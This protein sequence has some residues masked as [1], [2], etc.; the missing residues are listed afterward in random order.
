M[1]RAVA[2]AILVA[3]LGCA[4]PGSP[5]GGEIDRSPPRVIETVPAA[6]DTLTDLGE[7]AIIRFDER[8]SERLQG[9]AEL[10]EAVLVSPAGREIRVDRHSRSFEIIP[11]GGW[12]PDRVY[13]IQV[14][15]VFQD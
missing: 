2:G 9:V 1:S 5:P 14:L 13:R 7:P 3:A 10:R 15:P 11:R 8:I 6:F 4:Q 12:E